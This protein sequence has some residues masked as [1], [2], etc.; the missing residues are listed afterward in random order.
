MSKFSYTVVSF[1]YCLSGAAFHAL[2]LLN[3]QEF[4]VIVEWKATRGLADDMDGYMTPHS[5]KVLAFVLGCAIDAI[6]G[7]TDKARQTVRA[8]LCTVYQ[9]LHHLRV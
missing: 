9:R 7:T 8:E 5:L 4:S 3:H 2:Q 6:G 1:P